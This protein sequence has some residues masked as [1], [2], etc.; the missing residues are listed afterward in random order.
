M[1]T[2]WVVREIRPERGVLWGVYTAE[3]DALAR[4]HELEVF[5]VKTWAGRFI[6][7]VVQ[8]QLKEAY[9]PS[10]FYK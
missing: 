5:A 8:C 6:F 3:K 10:E 4:K 2:V 9:E 1:K 7:E